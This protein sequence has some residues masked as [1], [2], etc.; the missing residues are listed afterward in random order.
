MEQNLPFSGKLQQSAVVEELDPDG[1]KDFKDKTR[2]EQD[3][4]L[5]KVGL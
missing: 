3:K 1:S 2:D 5:D 4:I